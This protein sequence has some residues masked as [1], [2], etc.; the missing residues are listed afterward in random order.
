MKLKLPNKSYYFLI[1]IAL[2]YLLTY[3]IKP[4]F[5]IPSLIYSKKIF[6]NIIPIFILVFIIMFITNYFIS[7]KTLVKKLSKKRKRNWS[8]VLL[9]GI[10]STGPIYMWY[11]LL[12][13]LK[14][15]GLREGFIATFLYARA[16][17]PAL[18]PLMIFY[19]GLTFT[20]II[21]INII[22]FSIIQGITLEKITGGIKK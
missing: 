15:K 14:E 21:T 17:K 2:I 4:D 8:F 20:I 3:F 19:F 11:P 18:I 1:I 13:E 7:P 16:V 10:I 6:I 22:I 9:A 5:L 12:S